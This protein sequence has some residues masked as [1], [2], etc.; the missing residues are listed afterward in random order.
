MGHREENSDARRDDPKRE[1]LRWWRAVEGFEQERECNFQA[2]HVMDAE[3]DFFELLSQMT[4]SGTRFVIRAGQLDR[5]VTADDEAMKLREFVDSLQ[6]MTQRTVRL[7]ARRYLGRRQP[8]TTKKRHPAREARDALLN[9]AAASLSL[10]KTRYSKG[11]R[12][13]V[14]LNVL[15]SGNPTLLKT[16]SPSNGSC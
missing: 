5:N 13:D 15:R 11:D 16:H 1:S 2:I 14:Q 7:S 12:D 4:S 10:R 3:A 6:S 8:A 9:I